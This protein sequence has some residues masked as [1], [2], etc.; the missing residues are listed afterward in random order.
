MPEYLPGVA[1]EAVIGR[2]AE[3]A[4]IAGTLAESRIRAVVIEGPAGIGKST[5]WR[6]AMADARRANE[7]V[8]I[9]RPR[10]VEARMPYAGLEGLLSERLADVAAD[11]PSPQRRALDV[12]LM[13]VDPAADAV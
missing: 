5:L 6:A 3:L 4:D 10:E 1:S 2:D 7:C 9:V 8:L 12:A 11:L 13:R